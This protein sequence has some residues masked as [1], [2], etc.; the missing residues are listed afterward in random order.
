MTPRELPLGFRIAACDAGIAKGER[1]DLMLAVAD[2]AFPYAAVF[3]KNRIVAAPVALCREHARRSG[4]RARA[5]LVN[6]G[7]A[8]C[9]T[10]PEGDADAMRSAEIVAQTL[11]C[12]VE[13]VLVLSTG[14]IGQRLPMD[15][16]ESAIPGLF[17]GLGREP[18][19]ILAAAEAIRTTDTC[20][21]IEERTLDLAED[22]RGHLLGMAKGS[23]MIHPD[24]ATMLAFLFSDIEPGLELGMALRAA[25]D[26]SFN[27]ISV[28]NDTSTNDAVIL[29]TSA[30]KEMA[31]GPQAFLKALDEISLALA[32][33][34]AADGEG[35]TKLVRIHVRGASTQSDARLCAQT[36]ATSL[37]VKTA[38][39]GEDP[40]WGR[41]LAAAGRSGAEIDTRKVQVG[42][43]TVTLFEDDHPCPDR[44]PE[45]AA[46]MKQPEVLLWVDLGCGV[47]EAEAWTCDLGA[48][49]VRINADYRT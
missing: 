19:Q 32:R 48:D 37:L 8:N 34:I 47:L 33:K 45:A 28:D 21:K 15:R 6:A 42:I 31:Q 7:N 2:E 40:N 29:W 3:T 9:C 12:P 49:Y 11:A 26:M 4:H 10:G 39:H 17:D 24:M 14:V 13:E 5:L 30:R 38:V 27:R 22:R 35:A 41:I 43:G 18:A 16:L 46:H 23:G 36:I 25:V 20:A 1:P 44:E